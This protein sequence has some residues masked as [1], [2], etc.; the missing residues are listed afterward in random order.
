MTVT[1]LFKGEQQ[2]PQPFGPVR[3]LEQFA[4]RERAVFPRLLASK[5]NGNGAGERPDGRRVV[6]TG[7]QPVGIGEEVEMGAAR[8]PVRSYPSLP[9]TPAQ[10]A[11]HEPDHDENHDREAE[12][13]PD[14][15]R[16]VEAEVTDPGPREKIRDLVDDE[17][18]NLLEQRR[19]GT[20]PGIA[21][22]GKDPLQLVPGAGRVRG[23]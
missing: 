19:T 10:D 16:D 1:R 7:G 17:A 12:P 13:Q 11:T 18:E 23:I 22:L 21:R 5:P 9:S 3:L 6:M 14:P 4:H 15:D 8:R 20:Q 2:R